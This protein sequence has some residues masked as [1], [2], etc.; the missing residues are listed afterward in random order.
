MTLKFK[1]L[2]NLSSMRLCLLCYSSLGNL[3]DGEIQ[4]GHLITLFGSKGHFLK[5][6]NLTV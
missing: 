4:T 5:K 3:P 1:G 2:S 6:L